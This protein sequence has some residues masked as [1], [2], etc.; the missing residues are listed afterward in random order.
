MSVDEQA[1]R[2]ALAKLDG[3]DEA[4]LSLLTG[5]SKDEIREL[6]GVIETGRECSC[7]EDLREAQMYIRNL[8][9][10]IREL[11]DRLM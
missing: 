5:M 10:Q 3:T 8:E 2:D 9:H 4:R 7:K 1:I 6:G 11:R